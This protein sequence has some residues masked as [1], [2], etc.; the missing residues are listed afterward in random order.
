MALTSKGSK[1]ENKNSLY[2]LLGLIPVIN[3]MAFFHM[4]GR[5]KN[6]KWSTLGWASLI[7][8]LVLIMICIV[9]MFIAN[10]FD[11]PSYDIDPP[12][13][14]DYMN[15]EQKKLY[16]EDR[17]YEY[18]TEFKLTEEYEKYNTAYEKW[19]DDEE[20]WEQQPD[21]AEQIAKHDNFSNFTHSLPF[22][23]L[24]V[25]CVA[26]FIFFVIVLTERPKYLKLLAQSSNRRIVQDKINESELKASDSNAGANNIAHNEPSLAQTATAETVDINTA[27]EDTL[28]AL[29]GLTIID[30]KKAIAYREEHNG[31][32]STD[33]FFDCINAKPHIIVSLE[34]QLTV[35]EYKTVQPP[36]TD[37]SGKRMLDL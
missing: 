14:E 7:L 2:V 18:S 8:N 31:F 1:W 11:C 22:I 30:A 13:I 6:K 27:D 16:Y 4:S 12:K 37:N 24:L 21:I 19:S 34:K 23:G 33:E 29:Q 3:C 9:P 20:K 25:L 28:S 5:V 17:S 36:K 15:Q 35:G 32:N 10:P 26:D